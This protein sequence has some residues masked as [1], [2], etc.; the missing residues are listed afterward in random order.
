[1]CTEPTHDTARSRSATLDGIAFKQPSCIFEHAHKQPETTHVRALMCAR[2]ISG[3]RSRG[4]DRGSYGRGGKSHWR[5]VVFS[6]FTLRIKILTVHVS[7]HP[8]IKT[9]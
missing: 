9:A 7:C 4:E 2:A 1:M 3:P 5:F 8:H 6:F